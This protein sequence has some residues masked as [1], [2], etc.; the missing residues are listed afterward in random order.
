MTRSAQAVALADAE[1]RIERL[2]EANERLRKALTY[3]MDKCSLYG[4]ADQAR[5]LARQALA[6]S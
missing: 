5:E 1:K 6:R 4:P 2:E 3:T